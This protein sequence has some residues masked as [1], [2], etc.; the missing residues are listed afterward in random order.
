MAERRIQKGLA[1]NLAQIAS[2][3]DEI[4]VDLPRL[5]ESLGVTE[6]LLTELV[7]DGRTTW[8]DGRPRIELR[9]DRPAARMRFT[10]AHEIAHVL[11]AQDQT[12]A[13]RTQGL[14]HDVLETLCDWVAASILMPRDWMQRFA[15]RDDYNLSLLRLI[16][17]HADVSLSSAAVRLSEVGGRTCMLLRLQRAPRRW[18]VVGH[19]GVPREY[20]GTLEVTSETSLLLDNL[21]SRRD[22]W[23]DLTLTAHRKNL[24]ASAHVDRS[25]QT[26]IALITSLSKE[27]G[28][29]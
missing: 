23:R 9:A 6:I 14:D 25:G 24:V 16:A 8:V 2:Q 4:P 1:E 27:E 15:E 21:E 13:R 10:L 20:V 3:G 28:T 7:E 19:A 18:V 29:E 22:T 11:V 5:A 12:V 26:C 17:N